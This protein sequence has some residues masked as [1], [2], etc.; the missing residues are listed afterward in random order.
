M[1]AVTPS[2]AT[3]QRVAIKPAPESLTPGVVADARRSLGGQLAVTR[4]AVGVTQ[5]RLARMVQW[6]RSTVANVETAR[7]VA[8]REFWLA[9]D[10]ALGA[11]G[12]LVAEWART[13]ALAR[14][15]REQM[16]SELVR[17]RLAQSPPMC[18]CRDLRRLL[19]LANSSRSLGIS[20]AA[21]ISGDGAG[22]G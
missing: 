18:V 21:L 10:V 2:H 6:S 3:A 9:C 20:P 5:V 16:V 4:K 17:Q 11:G 13:D 7:Q 19:D 22:H 14:R 15:L 1:V 8:P 12:L